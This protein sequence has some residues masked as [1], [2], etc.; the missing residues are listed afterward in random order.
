MV[1]N[2]HKRPFIASLPCE[3]LSAIF[4]QGPTDPEDQTQ[5]AMSVSQ[6]L[7]YWRET[8]TQ[9]RYI[10]SGII[11]FLWRTR[12]GY[13]KFLKVLVSRSQSHP[14][15][16][17]ILLNELDKLLSFDLH[18]LSPQLDTVILKITRWPSFS[19]WCCRLDEISNLME[20][21]HQLSAPILESFCLYFTSGSG[22]M[23][24]DELWNIFEN[25]APM[26]SHVHWQS[27]YIITLTNYLVPLSSITSLHLEFGK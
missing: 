19:I 10:W 11:L 13:R 1:Y 22:E 16:V 14:L 23:S 5:F 7:R 26:L 17:K 20:S 15:D 21:L 24:R 25:G 12:K 2:Q 18:F 4:N 8:A 3:I 9:T 27:T 6:V